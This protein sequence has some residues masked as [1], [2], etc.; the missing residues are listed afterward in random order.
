MARSVGA[1]IAQSS[2]ESVEHVPAAS[3]LDE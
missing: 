1:V 2:V 3:V